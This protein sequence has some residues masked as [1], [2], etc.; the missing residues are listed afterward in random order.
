MERANEENPVPPL[1]RQCQKNIQA[2]LEDDRDNAFYF[3]D[4]IPE[5][6]PPTAEGRMRIDV[7]PASSLRKSVE[8]VLGPQGGTGGA[9]STLQGTHYE[10]TECVLKCCMKRPS[11]CRVCTH[12]ECS[13]MLKSWDTAKLR[14]TALE[15]ASDNDISSYDSAIIL[16]CTAFCDCPHSNSMTSI[17]RVYYIAISRGFVKR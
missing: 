9:S 17:A 6:V 11:S 10:L 12:L 4:R 14:E 2:A 3:A 8:G 16:L 1:A 5:L 15:C 13:Y 7:S